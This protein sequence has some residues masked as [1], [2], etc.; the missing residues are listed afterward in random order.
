MSI[1]E[2]ET[3]SGGALPIPYEVFLRPGRYRAARVRHPWVFASSIERVAAQDE[4][5][6]GDLGRVFSAEGDLLG[7]GMVNAQTPLAVRFLQFHDGP[8]D[9]GW[10][11]RVIGQAIKLRS[12]MVPPETDAYRLIHGEGDG[13]PGLVID[14]YGAFYI[15]QC[16]TA[17]MSRLQS[18]WLEALVE[19]TQPRGVF[20]RSHRAR[21]DR[22]LSRGDGLLWGEE[23]PER[24][25][26]EECGHRFWVD[27][28]G[29]QKTGFYL[30]QRENRRLVGGL[31]PGG[32]VLNAFSYSG[33]FGI[34][35]GKEGPAGQVVLVETSASAQELARANWELNELPAD[36]LVQVQDSAQEFLR[37]CSD[38][39]DLIILDPPAYA[40]EHRHVERA[41]RAYKDV[42]LWAMKRLAPGGYLVTFSCSQH[43]DPDLF[44]KIIF[45]ASIDAGVPLQ[46]LRRLGAG[47]DHPVHLDHPQGEY[48]KGLLLRAG[49]GGDVPVDPQAAT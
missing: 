46:W 13:L 49:S 11:R 20:E 4:A 1:E 44:Q 34:Y 24:H 33:A 10:F 25:Q 19:L 18:Y 48:L 16:M 35:A 2:T 17:G 37:E 22:N 6:P 43:V 21:R 28:R 30:D 9:D 27:L 36:K 14:R 38:T 39:Y 15:V 41:A 3:G 12:Q 40:K 47:S 8:I 7:I 26:I 23:P 29:G 5:Q 31:A 42:N 45:G 32:R